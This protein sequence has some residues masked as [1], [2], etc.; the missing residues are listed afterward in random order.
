MRVIAFL[1]FMSMSVPAFSQTGLADLKKQWSRQ[2]GA[3]NSMEAFIWNSSCRE[4]VTCQFDSFGGNSFGY[5][6]MWKYQGTCSTCAGDSKRGYLREVVEAGYQIIET[7]PSDGSVKVILQQKS[8]SEPRMRPPQMRAPE[9]Q[10]K[11]PV[12]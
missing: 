4:Y 12:D 7:K 2:N 5:G 1:I 6:D 3:D 8:A 10:E 11:A 9:E